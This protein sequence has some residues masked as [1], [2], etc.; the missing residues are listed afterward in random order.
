M[1]FAVSA[2][3]NA[4]HDRVL[5]RAGLVIAQRLR[6]VIGILAAELRVVGRLAVAVEAVT[7]LADFLGLRLAGRDVGGARAAPAQRERD[8]ATTSDARAATSSFAR[9]LVCGPPCE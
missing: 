5:A 2:P 6:E 1:S 8:A 3:A 9:R 4:R 7:R